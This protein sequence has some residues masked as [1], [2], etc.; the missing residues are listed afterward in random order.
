VLCGVV[1]LRSTARRRV[2]TAPS[3]LYDLN[4]AVK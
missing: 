2:G 1:G 4:T 3:S